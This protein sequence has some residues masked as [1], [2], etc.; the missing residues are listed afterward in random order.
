MLEELHA[1]P[2]EEYLPGWIRSISSF[3]VRADFS[4]KAIY[5]EYTENTP[6]TAAIVT[7]TMTGTRI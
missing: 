1:E 7:G 2:V 6:L 3:N 4:S 5:R